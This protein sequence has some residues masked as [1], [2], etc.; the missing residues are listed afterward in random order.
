MAGMLGQLPPGLRGLLAAEQMGQQ[1]SQNQLGQIG[2]LLSLQNSLAQQQ[3][4]QA[5]APLRQAKME[6]ELRNIN[7]PAPKWQV[8]ERFNEATGKKEKVLVDM[9][10]PANIMPFGGQE[11]RNLSFQNAGGSIIG[12]EPTTGERV[13][14]PIPTTA[15]PHQLWTQNV[16]FPQTQ[17]LTRRGQNIT[18]AGM[19]RPVFN[20]SVGGF[21][22]PPPVG[23]GGGGG[24]PVPQAQGY[25]PA[26]AGA[27]G[28]PQQAPQPQRP[29]QPTQ[30]GPQVIPVPGVGGGKAPPHYRFKPDGE[31]EP[32][33]GGAADTKVGERAEAVRKR[34]D[35]ALNRADLIIGKVDKALEQTGFL[36]TGIVGAMSGNVPGMPAYNYQKTLDT[37]I[38]NIGFQELQALREASPTGGALGQVAVKEL[39][40]LQSVLSSVDRGQSEGQQKESLRLIGN[41]FSN[42]KNAVRESRGLPPEPNKFAA[43]QKDPARRSTDKSNAGIKFL[44]FE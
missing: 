6:A 5:S 4:M 7:N 22:T 10:N 17:D 29:A 11:A 26:V 16:Q 36:T 28:M 18:L 41:H 19:N 13:G 38:G 24:R 21:I 44:G 8:S 20:E 23:V 33:P 32:I 35:N 15:T 37:I 34:E 42:W 40:M 30:Q 39:E 31:L 2:G 25:S 12:L 43:P 1:R 27:F 14:A 3:E 9:N